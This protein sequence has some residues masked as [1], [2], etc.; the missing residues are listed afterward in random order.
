MIVVWELRQHDLLSLTHHVYGG[1]WDDGI[2]Q[3]K[4]QYSKVQF[5]T[6]QY[7]TVQEGTV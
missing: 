5:S 4:A 1:V 3:G 6:V 2:E 7:S